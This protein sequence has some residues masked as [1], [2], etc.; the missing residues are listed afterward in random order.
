M[1]SLGPGTAWVCVCVLCIEVIFKRSYFSSMISD[2]KF[3]PL[4]LKAASSRRS[5]VGVLNKQRQW[6]SSLSS[7]HRKRF[8]VKATS[9]FKTP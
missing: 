9:Y 6:P 3:L 1:K 5:L 4:D 2:Q 7:L 8:H